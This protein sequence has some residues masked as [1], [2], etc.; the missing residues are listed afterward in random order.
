MSRNRSF[1][2]V[3]EKWFAHL[4]STASYSILSSFLAIRQLS[5]IIDLHSRTKESWKNCCTYF[6]SWLFRKCWLINE[7]IHGNSEEYMP[8]DKPKRQNQQQTIRCYSSKSRH[9]VYAWIISKSMLSIYI[10]R[11]FNQHTFI[12]NGFTA[13]KLRK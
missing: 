12:Y 13:R 7:C 4:I 8:C 9:L 3:Y 2:K 1:K 10:N 11:I 5:V 6:M